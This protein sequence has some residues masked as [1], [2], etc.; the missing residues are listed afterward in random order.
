MNDL[1]RFLAIC[2]G[3]QPDYV[4][5]YGFPGAPGM[6]RGCMAKTHDRLRATGMPG[7]VGGSFHLGHPLLRHLPHHWPR[8]SWL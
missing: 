2:R 6:S 3:E 5:I 8:L 7:H 4:P 1:E